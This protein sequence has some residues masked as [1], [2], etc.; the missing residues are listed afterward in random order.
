MYFDPIWRILA[1]VCC[2]MIDESKKLT[3]ST[4]NRS[5]ERPKATAHNKGGMEATGVVGQSST[6]NALNRNRIE[7]PTTRE[8]GTTELAITNQAM[9]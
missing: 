1:F 2:K 7:N 9:V 5:T 3:T 6:A 8:N 4:F